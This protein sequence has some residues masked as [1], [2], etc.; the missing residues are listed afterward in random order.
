MIIVDASRIGIR[1][2]PSIKKILSK[3]MYLKAKYF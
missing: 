2:N 1:P 3:P